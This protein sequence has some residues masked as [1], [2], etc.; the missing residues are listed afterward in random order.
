MRPTLFSHLMCVLIDSGEL[1]IFLR[2]FPEKLEIIYKA[3]L[4]V[5][6]GSA[7]FGWRG[8]YHCLHR[9]LTA[10]EQRDFLTREHTRKHS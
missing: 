4:W 8:I 5:I 3:F 1:S 2:F 6:Q 7:V 9:T 10:R